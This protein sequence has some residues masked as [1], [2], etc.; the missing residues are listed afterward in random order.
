MMEEIW[1]DIEGYEGLYQ[2]SNLG[3][4]RS[5][6]RMI[7]RDDK[8]IGKVI[9]FYHKG[10]ILRQAKTVDG[11]SQINLWKEGGCHTHRVHRLVAKAFIPN[12]DNLE[13]VNHKDENILNNRADN[14]EYLSVADNIRY[15]TGIARRRLSKRKPVEQLT[16]DGKHIA[17]YDGIIDASI[18]TGAP[19]ELIGKVCHGRKKTAGGYRWKFKEQ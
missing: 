4:V 6:S 12:P 9:T 1:K 13:T 8:W 18:A 16:K 17:Y 19:R 7:Q 3:R 2:V 11:Y 5:V 10:R 14:L 15:G